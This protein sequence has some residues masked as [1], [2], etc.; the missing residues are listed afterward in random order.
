[1][2]SELD[3]DWNLQILIKTHYWY[4]NFWFKHDLKLR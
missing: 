3:F 1:M 4:I 2:T